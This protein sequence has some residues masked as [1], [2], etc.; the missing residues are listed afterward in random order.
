MRAFY[1]LAKHAPPWKADFLGLTDFQVRTGLAAFAVRAEEFGRKRAIEF[2]VSFSFSLVFSTAA[3]A[4]GNKCSMH[5]FP[6]RLN[7]GSA[8]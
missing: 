4:L 5:A 1:L 2:S 3:W 6:S 7:H 8:E